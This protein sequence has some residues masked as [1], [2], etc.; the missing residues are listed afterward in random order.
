MEL[1]KAAIR[2]PTLSYYAEGNMFQ[3]RQRESLDSPA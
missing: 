1:R 2:T 3:G